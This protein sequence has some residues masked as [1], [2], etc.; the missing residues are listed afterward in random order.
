MFPEKDVIKFYLFLVEVVFGNTKHKTKM[1]LIEQIQVQELHLPFW[2]F[3]SKTVI[4]IVHH[5]LLI[6]N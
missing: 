3:H 4:C 2:R 5:H 6:W 1:V